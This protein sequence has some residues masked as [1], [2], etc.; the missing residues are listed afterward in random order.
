MRKLRVAGISAL[1]EPSAAASAT[2]EVTRSIHS[3]TLGTPLVVF[4]RCVSRRG[5]HC[6]A[7]IKVIIRTL[8]SNQLG[9]YKCIPV[10][11]N[12]ALANI[13]MLAIAKG[14]VAARLTQSAVIVALVMTMDSGT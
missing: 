4:R 9:I 5:W 2:T 7:G 6:D 8:I 11:V 3:A 13:E 12:G 1:Q 10:V 14:D